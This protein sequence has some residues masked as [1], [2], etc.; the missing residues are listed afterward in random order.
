MARAWAISSGSITAVQTLDRLLLRGDVRLCLGELRLQAAGIETRQQ[1]PAA[2]VIALDGEHL[3]DALAVVERQLDLAHI[4]VAVEGELVATRPAG[5]QP[6]RDG[7]RDED[8]QQQQCDAGCPGHQQRRPGYPPAVG[9]VRIRCPPVYGRAPEW[10]ATWIS[11]V[12]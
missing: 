9:G 5:E 8:E 1:L 10:K 2:H 4:D 3:G 11:P 7:G 6:P 12:R